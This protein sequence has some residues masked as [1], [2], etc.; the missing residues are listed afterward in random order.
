MRDRCFAPIQIANGIVLQQMTDDCWNHFLNRLTPLAFITL[1]HILK[2]PDT[3]VSDQIKACEIIG[4][5]AGL[6]EGINGAICR[7]SAAGYQV[8]VGASDN[9][10]N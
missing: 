1:L 6:N 3:R 4:R 5:W 10:L 2:N 9:E 7:V 8:S